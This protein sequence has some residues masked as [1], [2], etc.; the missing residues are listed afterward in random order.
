L[1]RTE[2][3]VEAGVLSHAYVGVRDNQSVALRITMAALTDARDSDAPKPES[4]NHRES[5]PEAVS[6]PRPLA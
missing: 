4:Q 2:P 3:T 5:A 6:L 1:L